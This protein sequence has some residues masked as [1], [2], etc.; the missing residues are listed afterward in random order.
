M[1]KKLLLA[2]LVFASPLHAQLLTFEDIP[3]T[4]TFGYLG[5][6]YTPYAPLGLT[7]TGWCFSNG[8]YPAVSGKFSLY[9]SDG[10]VTG[11][12]RS[13][14]P[15]FSSTSA[16]GVSSVWVRNY[17]ST[18]LVTFNGYLSGNL[19]ATKNVVPGSTYQ[20]VMFGNNFAN[21]DAFE[22]TV[23]QEQYAFID[24]LDLKVASTV[25]EPSALLLTG[26]GLS[27]LAATRRRRR[28]NA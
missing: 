2:T 24:D 13:Y 18:P 22:M 9:N 25:P 19:V 16:F 27:A 1:M 11:A 8:A 6:G 20:Q 12:P 26:V 28:T 10:C 15:R 14:A 21:I 4:A 7:P 3:S 23:A 5:T 17:V